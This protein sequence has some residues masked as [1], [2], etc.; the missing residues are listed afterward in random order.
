MMN[1]K[2]TDTALRTYEENISYL[3]E[4]WTYK[5][6]ENFIEATEQAINN[7]SNNP[8]IGSISED[9]PHFRKYLVVPQIYLYYRVISPTDIYL[10]VFFNNFQDPNNLSQILIS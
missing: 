5:E 9:N 1:I 4:D 10:A 6:V 8:Y 2:W 3:F 7:I